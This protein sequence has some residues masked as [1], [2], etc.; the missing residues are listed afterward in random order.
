MKSV[1][2]GLLSRF[3]R[4]CKGPEEAYGIGGTKRIV[5]PE[6]GGSE[7]SLLDDIHCGN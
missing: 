2:K 7:R 5:R 3:H 6:R 4:M 1:R